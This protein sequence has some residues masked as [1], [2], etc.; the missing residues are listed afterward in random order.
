M[1]SVYPLFHFKEHSNSTLSFLLSI[2]I[3][4][5]NTSFPFLLINFSLFAS[6]KSTNSMTPP[7]NLNSDIFSFF[8]LESIKV[9]FIPL[10]KKANSLI[11]LIKIF[12]LNLIAEKISFEGKKVISVPLFLDLP[13]IF[14]G[15][16]A[17]P[18]LNS[19]KY[20]LPSLL[21]SNC[22]FSDKALTTDTPTPCKPPD[23]LYES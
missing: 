8:W 11:L 19:I 9:I 21:I 2:K 23:T 10:F 20:F 13:T 14:I 17:S 6:R 12:G 7:S 5:L 4:F 1:S 18:F 15:D 16:F 3:G 22:N